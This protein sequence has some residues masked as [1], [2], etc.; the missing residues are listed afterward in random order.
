MEGTQ[1]EIGKLEE[2]VQ[3]LSGKITILDSDLTQL[4][5]LLVNRVHATYIKAITTD[6]VYL[7]LSSNGFGDFLKTV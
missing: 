4:T 5:E 2:E 1:A 7:F 3:A 6:P